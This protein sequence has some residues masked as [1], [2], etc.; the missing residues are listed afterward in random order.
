M[1]RTLIIL[2]LTI[3]AIGLVWPWLGRIGLGRLPGDISIVRD[4]FRFYAPL[5]TSL[6]IS[7]VLS[8]LLWL[9]N[10]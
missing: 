4:G 7:V 10:R 1:S 9:L 2:G 6:L 8:L 3:A 5:G